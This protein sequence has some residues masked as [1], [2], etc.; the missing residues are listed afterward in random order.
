MGILTVA[1]FSSF[2]IQKYIASIIETNNNSD[3]DGN[4]CNVQYHHQHNV[5]HGM[6]FLKKHHRCYCEDVSSTMF[7]VV[8]LS[9]RTCRFESQ[10]ADLDLMISASFFFELGPIS[11]VG[12]VSNKTS[13][14][15][16]EALQ[17]SGTGN[18]SKQTLEVFKSKA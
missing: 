16:S 12:L 5:P 7:T 17:V 2:L 15:S 18:K 4:R 11:H 13:M 14:S 6:H 9:F 3:N 10:S 1:F 8:V